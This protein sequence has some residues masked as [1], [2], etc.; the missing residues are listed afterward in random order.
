MTYHSIMSTSS[1][2]INGLKWARKLGATLT[3]Y[4]GVEIFPYSVFY[5]YYEQYLTTIQDMALNIGVSIG[6]GSSLCFSPVLVGTR[7]K[8]SAP[9]ITLK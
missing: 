4:T 5:V 2:F 9:M 1:N 8:K 3:N 6:K 7:F